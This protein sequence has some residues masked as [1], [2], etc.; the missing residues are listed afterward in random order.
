M[1]SYLALDVGRARI[2]L[3]LANSIARIA[4][5]LP[6]I[7]NDDQTFF[8]LQQLVHDNAITKVVVGWPRNLRGQNTEQTEYVA[9]FTTELQEFLPGVHI[10]HQ[11]EALTSVKAEAELQA[12]GRPYTKG[13]IDSLSAVYI[14]EDFLAGE[15][16]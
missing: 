3:A 9:K 16:Q 2:G 14:M 8:G 6:A 5:P 11:D 1:T 13:D 4:S 7:A 10:I 12:R 15:V